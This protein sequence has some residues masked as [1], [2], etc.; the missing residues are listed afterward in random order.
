MVAISSS[1]KPLLM[2]GSGN[3]HNAYEVPKK[4]ISFVI[5][6][7]SPGLYNQ[8]INTMAGEGCFLGVYREVAP[9]T[10]VTFS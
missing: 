6:S 7:L 1:L 4:P 3:A 10:P 9:G 5:F 8:S 2:A